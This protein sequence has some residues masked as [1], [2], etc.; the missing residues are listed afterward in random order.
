MTR[1]EWCLLRTWGSFAP[2]ARW[3]RRLRSE[4]GSAAVLDVAS[5]PVPPR[6]T[7]ERPRR[8]FQRQLTS[9][10]LAPKPAFAPS[11]AATPAPTM[12]STTYVLPNAGPCI[13]VLA[14]PHAT[15]TAAPVTAPPQYRRRSR[16]RATL[17][18]P[19]AAVRMR[20]VAVRPGAMA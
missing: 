11:V 6:V 19:G 17:D 18:T 10:W 12:S 7:T 8:A 14:L 9:S 20:S 1:T 3:L 4:R 15:T 2:V 13:D 16:G 5:I